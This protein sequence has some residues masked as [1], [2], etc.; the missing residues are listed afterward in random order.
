MVMPMP[1]HMHELGRY[2][3]LKR[4]KAFLTRDGIMRKDLCALDRNTM[5]SVVTHQGNGKRQNSD[6]QKAQ[7]LHSEPDISGRP[8]LLSMGKRACMEMYED[9]EKTE[10][11]AASV[12][13]ILPLKRNWADN[14]YFMPEWCH[15]NRGEDMVMSNIMYLHPGNLWRAW[16]LK[17]H[18]G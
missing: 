4:S 10:S 11:S 16:V 1:E 3:M 12:E 17:M 5:Y 15:D 2:I 6:A 8:A 18:N 14:T 13:A 7:C 9:S